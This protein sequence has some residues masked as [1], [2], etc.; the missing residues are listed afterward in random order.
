MLRNKTIVIFIL[1]A[2]L[3]LFHVSLMD[4]ITNN[5]RLNRLFRTEDTLDKLRAQEMC[6]RDRSCTGGLLSGRLVNAPGIS[7][8]FR[9][10]YIT[11][12]NEAKEKLLAVSHDTLERF[13]AVSEETAREMAE[14]VRRAAGADIGIGITGKMCIRDR[15]APRRRNQQVSFPP[16]R[17]WEQ[18]FLP[19]RPP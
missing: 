7:E 19:S 10:G 16:L 17:Y 1:L 14:G 8:S 9:E 12:S 4:N 3:V 6:I 11:Y 13:G 5:A 15:S 2:V 18:N